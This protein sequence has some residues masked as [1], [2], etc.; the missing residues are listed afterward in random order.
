MIATSLE[1]A[2]TVTA[3][4]AKFI[5]VVFSFSGGILKVIIGKRGS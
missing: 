5:I 3:Y 2:L 1:E 4:C